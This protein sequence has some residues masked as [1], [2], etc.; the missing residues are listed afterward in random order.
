MVPV[1]AVGF[2]DLK[3]RLKRQDKQALAHTA[4]IEKIE[5]NLASLQK[6]H[7]L[8][9]LPKIDQ[10]K[11]RHAELTHRVVHV[12]RML[13]Y[14]RSQRVP[15]VVEYS[16]EEENLRAK[17][18]AIQRE[19]DRPTQFSSKLN[20]LHS[21][22]E[23]IKESKQVGTEERFAV[24]DESSFQRLGLI[25]EEQQE[26][27]AVLTEITKNDKADLNTMVKGYQQAIKYL[28]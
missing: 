28:S 19:L 18:E 27:L 2:E 13:E 6:D 22:L 15:G 26:G 24:A 10:Y 16:I 1:E 5:K 23:L 12:M 4:A 14:L 21:A 3:K 20:E 7:D 11:R 25:L 8:G 9:T 17:F